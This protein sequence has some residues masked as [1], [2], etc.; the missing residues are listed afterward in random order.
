MLG[1]E[2]GVDA[3]HL[4]RTQTARVSIVPQ[5]IKNPRAAANVFVIRDDR[6]LPPDANGFRHIAAPPVN[7]P[8]E[9][10]RIAGAIPVRRQPDE[11]RQQLQPDVVADLPVRL[12][13]RFTRFESLRQMAYNG[14]PNGRSHVITD[15][16][17]DKLDDSGY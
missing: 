9:K 1:V 3:I 17:Y 12:S 16:S 5:N 8:H 10:P 14:K 2:D 13:G 6:H 4:V 7:R 11:R 15:G